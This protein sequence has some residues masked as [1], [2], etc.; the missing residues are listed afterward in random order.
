LVN[1]YLTESEATDFFFID[2]DIGFEPDDLITLLLYDEDIICAPCV[3]KSLRLDRIQKAVKEH[4]EKEYTQAEMEILMGE[5]VLNF[6]ADNAPKEIELTKLLKVHHAGTGLMRIKRET[7]IKFT[8]FHKEG[9]WHLPM[10]GEQENQPVYMYF[11]AEI[12]PESGKFN[13]GGLPHYISEDY[14]FCVNAKKAGMDT[15]IAPWMRTS[16]LGSYMF[17]GDMRSVALAGGSLR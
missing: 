9:R 13:P 11:Q 8:N 7:F 3:R 15:Y 12:D 17:T 2:A 10:R 1:R 16:H 5:Y 14:S 6:N 4:P